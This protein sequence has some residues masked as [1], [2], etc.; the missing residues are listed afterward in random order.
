MIINTVLLDFYTVSAGCSTSS[1][2]FGLVHHTNVVVQV[3][4]DCLQAS[5]KIHCTMSQMFVSVRMMES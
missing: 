5:Q 1:M 3:V 4:P 2:M